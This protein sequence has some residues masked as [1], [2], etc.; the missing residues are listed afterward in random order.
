VTLQVQFIS[1]IWMIGSG[2]IMGVVFDVYRVLQKKFRIKGWLISMLD[3]LYWT[4]ATVFVF[5]VLLSSNDGQLRFYIF[6]ALIAGLWIYFKKW[7]SLT[8]Q[9][10]LWLIQVIEIGIKWMLILID[11]LVIRPLMFI[12]FLGAWVGHVGMTAVCFIGKVIYIIFSPISFLLRPLIFFFLWLGKPIAIRMNP[13]KIMLTK[14][15]YKVIQWF[16]T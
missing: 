10:V 13:A 7:S 9:I 12:V 4:G 15:Y 3:L 8:I 6:M 5:L 16:K 2:I 14:C 1:L 11:A